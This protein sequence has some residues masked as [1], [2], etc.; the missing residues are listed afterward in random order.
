MIPIRN[1]LLVWALR[2]P[3]NNPLPRAIPK[4]ISDR[5]KVRLE[6]R[7]S[8]LFFMLFPFIVKLGL[9]PEC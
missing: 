7:G 8:L 9:A 6:K 1:E 5:L 2:T 4:H 3:A